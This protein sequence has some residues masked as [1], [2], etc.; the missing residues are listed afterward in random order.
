M[1][2]SGTAAARLPPAG[3]PIAASGIKAKRWVRPDSLN[4]SR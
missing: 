2:E 1:T 4:V 3:Q